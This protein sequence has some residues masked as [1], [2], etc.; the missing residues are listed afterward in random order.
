V[1]PAGEK[2]QLLERQEKVDRGILKSS[3]EVKGHAKVLVMP[4]TRSRSSNLPMA[5]VLHQVEPCLKVIID[6]RIHVTTHMRSSA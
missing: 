6:F 1:I 4:F 2:Q 3:S 5:P